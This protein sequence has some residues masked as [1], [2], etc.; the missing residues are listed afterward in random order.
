MRRTSGLATISSG[1]ALRQHLAGVD[2]IGAVDE[3]ERLA[4]VVIGDEHADAARL[5]MPHEI[6]D[7]ADRDR[8]DAGEGLVE[9]HEGGLAGEARAISQRRRSPPESAIAGVCAQPRESE[10]LEQP[11]SSSRA[12]SLVG[13]GHF[14][15]RANIVLDA[16]AAEN[17]RLLRQIADAEPRPTIHRQR[18]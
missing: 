14:Q 11:S 17:R 1:G 15:H 16:Q 18:A 7:V 13:L 5:Q 10:F 4:D 12:L 2:D 6:L 9:Q 8:V 3:A